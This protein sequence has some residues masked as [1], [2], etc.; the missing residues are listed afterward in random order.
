ME[1]Q[2]DPIREEIK[3]VQPF[4]NDGAAP[5]EPS[6]LEIAI[7]QAT[8]LIARAAVEVLQKDPNP[9]GN[10]NLFIANTAHEAKIEA[11]CSAL[12]KKG[13]LT[14]EEIQTAIVLSLT[15]G[16]KQ[17]HDMA[18]GMIMRPSAAGLGGRARRGG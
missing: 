5:R 15:N 13:L 9:A 14:P 18:A 12:V 1:D 7:A 10:L 16:A 17:I 4:T 8:Q 2:V 3:V 11:L 6:P